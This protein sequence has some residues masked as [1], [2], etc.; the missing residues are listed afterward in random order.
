MPANPESNE[1]DPDGDWWE[2][3]VQVS[4]DGQFVLRPTDDVPSDFE[5]MYSNEP[6]ARLGGTTPAA[7]MGKLLSEVAPPYGTGLRDALVESF[8]TRQ[9]V[10][11]TTERIAP[12]VHTRRAEFK[13]Q[14]FGGFLALSVIDR[15]DEFDA[16]AEANRLRGLLVAGVDKSP[17]AFALLRPVRDGKDV[18]DLHIEHVN[19]VAAS[20]LGRSVD[21]VVG[22]TLY[23][24]VARRGGLDKIVQRSITTRQMISVDW[25][26]RN[27][28]HV[29]DWVRIQVTPL[30][31]FVVLHA[32]DI[33]GERR[34][35]GLLREIV[36]N[37]GELVIFSDA[38]GFIRYVN[39]Y[40]V[41]TLGFPEAA[42]LES[43]ILAVTHP[44]DRAAVLEET[45]LMRKPSAKSRRQRIRAIDRNG[46]VRTMLGSTVAV[47]GTGGELTGMVTVA[48]DLTEL[49]AGEEAREQLAAELSMAEQH[50]RE[51]IAEE[52]HDGPVQDLTAL[53]MRLGAAISMKPNPEL[54]AAE[55]ILVRVIADLRLLMF[56][57]SPPELDGD[58]L[59]QAIH[60]R[61][62]HL[63][64]GMNVK[65]TIRGSLTPP[66]SPAM[67]VSFFRCAQEALVNS[68][69]HAQAKTIS[70]RLFDTPEKDAMVLEVVDDG[71]GA[72]PAQYRRH[73]AGHFG[74]SMIAERA[75]QLGG[76]CLIEGLPGQ[77]TRVTVQLPRLRS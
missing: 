7:V 68:F 55:D 47:W 38:N 6:G 26:V 48:A 40:T 46:D 32:E 58:G 72:E 45:A 29:A 64:S 17:T 31:D 60:Q 23:S 9:P 33:S 19:E 5:V 59:S 2:P 70:V 18:V 43:S 24:L 65:V 41:S 22:Q 13:V 63:F 62:E 74:L 1:L 77:G 34:E 16:E 4:L 25:D 56:Q 71:V 42:L 66:P 28:T 76:S 12:G 35:Q 21:E 30:G 61:A 20:M 14:P 75:R 44:D 27:L 36:E 51:R 3:L 54:L 67:A 10:H 50:E 39:P 8:R 73:A 69:K 52:L 57:L 15:T 11:R 53:S 37:A 49:L